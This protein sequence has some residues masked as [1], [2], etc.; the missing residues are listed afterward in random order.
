MIQEKTAQ[1]IE[2]FKMFEDWMEKYNYLIEMGQELPPIEAN[3]KVNENLIKGC[4]SKVWLHA[5]YDGKTVSF[6]V[7]S[8]AIITKGIA[9][10]LLRVFNHETTEEILA[11]DM[12]FIEELGL[13]QHLSPTRS[14]GLLS[15]IKQIRIYALAFQAKS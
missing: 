5:S 9:A 10:L 7:D 3:Y 15:M 14:N 8:D 6:A 2:E 1:L 13:H 11:A 4:Q 12:G